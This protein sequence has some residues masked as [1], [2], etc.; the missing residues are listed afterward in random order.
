MNWVKKSK[1]LIVVII[2]VLVGIFYI[3]DWYA[4]EVKIIY[5]P[6]SVVVIEKGVYKYKDLRERTTYT[7]TGSISTQLQL[8][9]GR[10]NGLSQEWYKNGQIEYETQFK[11]GRRNG[12]A[13]GWYKNGQIESKG[14]FKNDKQEGLSQWWYKN[15]QIESKGQFK[16]DKLEGLSQWWYEDGSVAVSI[17]YEDD[18]AVD[19]NF[20]NKNKACK[21]FYYSSTYLQRLCD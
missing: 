8:K 10:R 12:L 4:T 5:Y 16:N 13:Q 6:Y 14:Q 11:N 17:E 3:I 20:N 9:N 2:V 15:G 19:V 1:T 18:I 21:T 7:V